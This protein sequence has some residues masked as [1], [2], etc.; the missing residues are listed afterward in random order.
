MLASFD[1]INDSCLY[2]V[3]LHCSNCLAV[4]GLIFINNVEFLGCCIFL[5]ALASDAWL[6]FILLKSELAV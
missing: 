6:V 4:C 1:L 2:F 5:F 3:L